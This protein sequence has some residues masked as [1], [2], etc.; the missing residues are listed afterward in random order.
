M[1]KAVISLAFTAIFLAAL[2][3]ALE[4]LPVTG[5]NHVKRCDAQCDPRPLAFVDFTT[6]PPRCLCK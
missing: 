2:S 1:G 5:T 6:D 4:P 3:C